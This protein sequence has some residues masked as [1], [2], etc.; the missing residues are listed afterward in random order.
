MHTD[1]FNLQ[2]VQT[3]I[4]KSHVAINGT[5]L[6]QSSRKG[7]DHAFYI[8]HD[9]QQRIEDLIVTVETRRKNQKNLI[10]GTDKTLQSLQDLFSQLEQTND[11]AEQDRLIEN[12]A[13]KHKVSI[14]E[15][16]AENE[17][18]KRKLWEYENNYR[19][20]SFPPAK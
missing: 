6:D 20:G 13:C 2:D 3:A 10:Q 4:T 16:C 8:L 18:L 7:F 1:I 15:L 17:G 19:M 11:V 9:I 12:E 5:I 14:A